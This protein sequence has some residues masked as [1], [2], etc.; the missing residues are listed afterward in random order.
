MT[1]H[2]LLLLA[3]GAFVSQPLLA[4][5]DA[6][7]HEQAHEAG[8]GKKLGHD[9]KRGGDRD[10]KRKRPHMSPEMR[11]KMLDK[12]DSDADGKLSD[13]ERKSA[14]EG[15]RKQMLE[16]HDADGDGKLSEDER[17]AAGKARHDKMKGE[18]LKRFDKDGDGKL[19][20]EERPKRG[21]RDGQRGKSH[22]DDC[23]CPRCESGDG[24]H[25]DG[26]NGK[27]KGHHKRGGD[28]GKHKDHDKRGGDSD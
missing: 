5:E 20:D 6:P 7:G 9:K 15:F 25:G 11:Q 17:K 22:G 16:K 1:K 23:K 8:K 19:S 10:G 28:N 13:D 4:R 21:D 14:R 26:D 27:H 24:D 18:M 12:Y 2:I 3:A